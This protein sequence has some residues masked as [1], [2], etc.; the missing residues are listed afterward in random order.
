MI[1]L[2]SARPKTNHVRIGKSWKCGHLLYGPPGTGKSTMI[3]A[4]ANFLNYE[5]Y[6]LELN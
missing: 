5:V 4:I 6:D 2:D 3:A 1:L